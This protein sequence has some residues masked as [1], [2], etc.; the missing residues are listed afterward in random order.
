MIILKH[1]HPSLA[2]K[3]QFNI[4]SNHI[5]SLQPMFYN[6]YRKRMVQSDTNVNYLLNSY[7]SNVKLAGIGCTLIFLIY[8]PQFLNQFSVPESCYFLQ[9]FIGSSKSSRKF[10]VAT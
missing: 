10:L 4:V 8:I 3:Q 6:I 7:F 5:Y 1:D 2:Q 9:A